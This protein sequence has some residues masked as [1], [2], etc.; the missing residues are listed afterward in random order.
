[1]IKVA[2]FDL[3]GTLIEYESSWQT[4]HS[5][6]GVEHCDAQSNLEAYTRG[7]ITYTEW[8]EKDIALWLPKRPNLDDV[9]RAFSGRRAPAETVDAISSLHESGISTYIVSSGIDVL[10]Q[11]VGAQL[12][13]CRTYANELLA[14]RSGVLTGKGTCVVEPFK[15]YLNVADIARR[16]K[17]DLSEVACAGDTKYDISMFHG[18]GAKVAVNAKHRE[19]VDAADVSFDSITDAASYIIG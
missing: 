12:G 10:A 9:R 19:L 7:D 6:F 11:S 14:D 15:K 16:E 1:M 3:D 8:M 5:Y 13:V 2:V 17:A 4:L 18:V